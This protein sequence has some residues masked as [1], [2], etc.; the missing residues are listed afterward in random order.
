MGGEPARLIPRSDEAEAPFFSP[1]SQEIAFFQG[2]NL[3]TARVAGGEPTEAG[4]VNISHPGGTW[5][6]DDSKLVVPGFGGPLQRID[7][8]GEVIHEIDPEPGEQFFYPSSLPGAEHFLVSVHTLSSRSVVAM[9]RDGS[10]RTVVVDDGYYGRYAPTGHILW[11]IGRASCRE[12][13]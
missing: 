4:T 5:E 12:R 8:G 2:A 6:E 10:S 11:K 3:Q 9:S 1:D 13:V 7:P